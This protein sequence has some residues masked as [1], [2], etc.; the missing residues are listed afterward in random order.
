MPVQT[1]AVLSGAANGNK[2]EQ[3]VLA[4]ATRRNRAATIRGDAADHAADMR[5]REAPHA[6]PCSEHEDDAT[7]NTCTQGFCKDT[8]GM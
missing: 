7:G 3:L 6:T 2:A 8:R 1:R 5:R 4:S